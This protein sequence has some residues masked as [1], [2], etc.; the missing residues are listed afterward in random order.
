MNKEIENYITNSRQSGILDDQIKK[1]LLAAG[2][3]EK[4]VGQFFSELLQDKINTGRSIIIA[5]VLTLLVPL[6]YLGCFDACRWDFTPL[7]LSGLHWFIFIRFSFFGIIAPFVY[8]FLF[9]LLFKK[10]GL[11]KYFIPALILILVILPVFRY[12]YVVQYSGGSGSNLLN[13]YLFHV[14]LI[15]LGFATYA[16]AGFINPFLMKLPYWLAISLLLPFYAAYII[17]VVWVAIRVFAK[18]SLKQ[19]WFKCSKFVLLAALV[20]VIAGVLIDPFLKKPL[21]NNIFNVNS[22]NDCGLIN[23]SLVRPRGVYPKE[24]QDVI[25][26]SSI[27]DYSLGGARKSCFIWQAIKNKSPAICAFDGGS[28]ASDC[29][30]FYTAVYPETSCR[31]LKIDLEKKPDQFYGTEKSYRRTTDEIYQE[32]ERE[33]LISRNQKYLYG[34]DRTRG[35]LGVNSPEECDVLSMNAPLLLDDRPSEFKKIDETIKNLNDYEDY[36]PGIYSERWVCHTWQAH[37]NSDPSICLDGRGN[38]YNSNFFK[39]CIFFYNQ[40]RP[41][42]KFCEKHAQEFKNAAAIMS[43]TPYPYPNQ[44]IIKQETVV[45]ICKNAIK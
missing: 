7:I 40:L 4:N 26:T 8:F 45:E 21:A 18:T 22:A 15:F 6:P 44:E 19:S 9:F 13:Y 35:V 23:Q 17:S 12:R 16:K 1:D 10:F 34:G 41:E 33:K 36:S 42:N 37:K 20:M 3:Q 43:P 39:S 24:L 28:W 29:L 38:Y 11:K 2:W 31:D 30:Y 14:N 27:G 25:N 5:L 32:C